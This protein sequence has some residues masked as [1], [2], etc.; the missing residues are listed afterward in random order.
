MISI[1]F[2]PEKYSI[3]FVAMEYLQPVQIFECIW[4]INKHTLWR[5]ILI[6]MSA[7]YVRLFQCENSDFYSYSSQ[8]FISNAINTILRSINLSTHAE[9]VL[10]I[11]IAI[12]KDCEFCS[13]IFYRWFALGIDFRINITINRT[14]CW[15]LLLM[16]VHPNAISCHIAPRTDWIFDSLNNYFIF[17]VFA[18]DAFEERYR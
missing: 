3:C 15:M 7:W 2:Y 14:N 8:R 9:K 10:T 18:N 5:C 6:E 16:P 1:H 13:A 12:F 4:W 11:I 17:V